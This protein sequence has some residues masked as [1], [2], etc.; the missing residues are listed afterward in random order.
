MELETTG[1]QLQGYSEIMTAAIGKFDDAI[2]TASS[3]SFTLP[4]TWINGQDYTSADLVR[5][6]NSHAARYLASV[7][8]TPAG[9]AAVN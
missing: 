6:V 7:A 9:R 1:F 3:Q 8:R 4:S 2:A 5:I